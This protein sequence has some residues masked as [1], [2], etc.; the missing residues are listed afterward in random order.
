MSSLRIIISIALNSYYDKA[1]YLQ[2]YAVDIGIKTSHAFYTV[3]ASEESLLNNTQSISDITTGDNT[4]R[5]GDF[6]APFTQLSCRSLRTLQHVDHLPPYL[7]RF[8]FRDARY[9]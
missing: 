9:I 3:S 7:L 2:L 8:G 6:G 4:K 1:F 5:G